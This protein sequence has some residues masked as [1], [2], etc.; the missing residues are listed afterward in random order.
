MEA[1]KNSKKVAVIILNYENYEDTLECIDSLTNN[2]SKNVDIIVVDNKS[3]NNSVN[4]LKNKTDKIDKLLVN[5]KNLGYA[6]GNN[7]GIQ[8]AY[9]QGY[10]YVCILNND[11]I[12]TENF[13]EKLQNYLDN[14]LECGIIGPAILEYDKDNI[15]QSTGGEIVYWRARTF[16]LNS[17]ISYDKIDKTPNEVEWIGGACMMFRS[18][19]IKK[20]GYIPE[21]Y[22]LF[23]EETDWCCQARKA[24]IKVVCQPDAYIYHKRSASVKNMKG[25]S[26]YLMER[27]RVRFV[28]RTAPLPLKFISIGLLFIWTAVKIILKKPDCKEKMQCYWDGLINRINDAYPFVIIR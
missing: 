20:I 17:M 21:C 9:E 2:V 22:F 19:I 10:K 12:V 5:E 6:G 28:I 7:V 16:L 18:E 8:Y 1:G 26:F 27:N 4:E 13:I 24:G 11:T 15:I 25:L 3:T 14:H 23:Y